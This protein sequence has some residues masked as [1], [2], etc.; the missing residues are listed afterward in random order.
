MRKIFLA[1]IMSFLLLSGC[2]MS[3]K[4][5]VIKIAVNDNDYRVSEAKQFTQIQYT[6]NNGLPNKIYFEST[7]CGQPLKIYQLSENNQW[8]WR[9]DLV[10]VCMGL[11]PGKDTPS[12]LKSGSK[13]NK[14]I[15]VS[16]SGTFKIDFIYYLNE[17]DYKNRTNIQSISSNQFTISSQNATKNS[18]I[19]ACKA[20]GPRESRVVECLYVSAKNI[21]TENLDLAINLCNEIKNMRHGFDGCYDGVALMLQKNGMTEKADMVCKKYGVADRIKQCV[22]LVK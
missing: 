6:I 18:I 2:S 14:S 3:T 9:S 7:E 1:S 19:D 11:A 21:A 17:N 5:G 12:V 16:K 15:S 22:D 8:E 20:D 13:F 10:S 4:S